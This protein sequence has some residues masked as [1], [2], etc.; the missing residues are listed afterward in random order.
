MIKLT[1]FSSYLA[2]IFDVR[3]IANLILHCIETN[4]AGILPILLCQTL[5]CGYSIILKLQTHYYEYNVN[6]MRLYQIIQ[7]FLLLE[8]TFTFNKDGE[9]KLQVQKLEVKIE[10]MNLIFFSSYIII[11]LD[12]RPYTTKI[13]WLDKDHLTIRVISVINHIKIPYFNIYV[14]EGKEAKMK[15]VYYIIQ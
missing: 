14:I 12:L 1:I 9:I 7:N 6:F 3:Q 13:S 15:V 5:S 11:Q 2:L 4:K 8:L 10:I